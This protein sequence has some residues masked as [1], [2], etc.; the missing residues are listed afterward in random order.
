MTEPKESRQ[1]L[2]PDDLQDVLDSAGNAARKG[3]QQ[4]LTPP[5]LARAIV[6]PLPRHRAIAADFTCGTGELLRGMDART[7]LGV[8]IDSRVVNAASTMPHSGSTQSWQ[9]QTADFTLLYDLL[10]DADCRFDL[11]ALNPPFSLTWETKRF[12]ALATS[13]R[14]DFRRFESAGLELAEG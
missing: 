8:D 3:T 9:T 6:L 7:C 4:F 13:N 10:A 1:T 5:A 2:R 11:L 12:A 14:A